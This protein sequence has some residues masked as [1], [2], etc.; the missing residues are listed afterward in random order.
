MVTNREHKR[1]VVMGGGTGTFPVISGLKHLFLD[2]RC[3][4]AVSDDG[5]STG[6]IRDEFGFQPVGD[7]R[8]ALAALA[9]ETTKVEIREMLLY[10]FQHGSGLKGH[11][12]GNL[13]LTAMQDMYGDTT[14]A[15]AVLARIL[16]VKGQVIP[17]TADNVHLHIHYKDGGEEIGEHI[18][19]V[20]AGEPRPIS[21][22][23]LTP[24]ATLN[25]PAAE[26][27]IN[28]DMIVIGPGDYY[29]SLLATLTPEGIKTAFAQTKAKKVFI[30]NLMTRF[31]QTHGMSEVDHVRG[32]EAAIGQPLEVIVVNNQP[33]SEAILSA[34]AAQK[35]YPV[36]H[37]LH[38]DK[39]VILAPLL[40]DEVHQKVANDTAHRSLLRHDKTK[41]STVLQ[42]VLWQSS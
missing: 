12:L 1:V 15:L 40:S 27:I 11:N 4:I 30:M 36:K 33:I 3:V 7:L 19:D 42:K 37:D 5:G 8:Q 21:H 39:R 16:R 10:R 22:V 26:A 9:E 6:R 18:L 29:A 34:Y 2:L 31:T 38:N 20:D 14:K 17:V 24:F 13:I 28:A 35:E 32:I 25:P 41:V 23:S